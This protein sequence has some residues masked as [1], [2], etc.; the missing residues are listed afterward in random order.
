MARSPII[1]VG[2]QIRQ[3]STVQI[4]HATASRRTTIWATEASS[5][6]SGSHA[7]FIAARKI[8]GRRDP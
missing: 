2:V 8:F 5:S 3:S 6:Y 7:G 4:W 1:I